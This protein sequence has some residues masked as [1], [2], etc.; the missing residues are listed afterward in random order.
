[1]YKVIF[2]TDIADAEFVRLA[3]E[4]LEGFA[5]VEQR[6]CKSEDDLL[7]K[8]A[9][10]DATISIFEPFT[11][12][13]FA[14]LPKLKLVAVSGVGYNFIDARAAAAQGVAVCNNPGY[15]I[16]EVADHTAALILALSR[17][18]VDYYLAVK[19]DK[20]WAAAAQKG[21]MHRLSTQTLGLL[22][23]GNIARLTARRMLGF[24]LPILAYDPYL[25]DAVFEE[26][27]VTRCRTV[28]EIYAGADIVSL[29]LPLTAETERMI[30]RAAFEKMSVR[31]PYFINCSRGGLVDEEALV[32]ALR[33]GRLRGAGLDAIS[34]EHPDLHRLA[35]ADTGP[36]V[37]LTPHAAYLS[38][39]ATRDQK[40]STSTFVRDF[41]SGQADRV[42]I[43]NGI[44]KCR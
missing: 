38:E 23:F 27:G 13:V 16:E 11:E 12:R 42:P 4:I 6:V 31:R 20:V 9:K 19:Q 10:A 29:H 24:G 44:K 43:V 25:P 35:L 34:T 37:I 30:D 8:C 3:R 32:E 14:G 15:C 36:E 39:E 1:M 28:D 40:V 21:R 33:A 2:T 7:S 18:I 17:K 26:M 5:E 41:L 22:G